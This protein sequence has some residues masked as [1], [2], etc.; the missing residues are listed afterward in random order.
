MSCVCVVVVGGVGAGG[1]GGKLYFEQIIHKTSLVRIIKPRVSFCR[2]IVTV[3][4][5]WEN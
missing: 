3:T 1:G 5:L 2:Y 4:Q